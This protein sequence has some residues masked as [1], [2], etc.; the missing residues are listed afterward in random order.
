MI[1]QEVDVKG[2]KYEDRINFAD[3]SRL[4]YKAVL[5]CIFVVFLGDIIYYVTSPT[6]GDFLSW[7][8]KLARAVVVPT[9]IQLIILLVAIRVTNHYIR[10]DNPIMQ[11][12]TTCTLASLLCFSM[13]VFFYEINV[14]Y[15][16][17]A[18]PMFAALLYIDRKPL[19]YVFVLD[20]LLYGLF[21]AL[22][23]P[24][25]PDAVSARHG[26]YE[27]MAII[28]FMVCV[29]IIANGLLAAL[30]KLVNNIIA[31]DEQLK[32]DSF[33]MLFNHTAF[34]ERL[35]VMINENMTNGTPFTLVIWDID[36]FKKVNDTYGHE[37]GDKV[38]LIFA[39]TLH[40]MVG[41]A[42]YAFRYG[43]DEFTMLVRM[44]ARSASRL[45]LSIR[46]TFTRMTR[47]LK[48]NA[49][50]T[51]SAGL[52]EYNHK[53]FYGS[54]DFF[55]AC[56]DALYAAKADRNTIKIWQKNPEE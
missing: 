45:A 30:S 37:L 40:N 46:D 47:D 23:L 7:F 54:N 49:K 4:L 3:W 14:V 17:M 1:W 56:D 31:K 22:I 43:G 15:V 29:F 12:L 8:A 20:L 6:D 32:R 19:I 11:A 42:N 24:S 5:L 2:L 13:I 35:E 28:E 25:L 9:A 53:H 50:F 10:L 52:C 21:L 44:D 18:V 48:R 41:D 55:K 27:R 26:P 16:V 39:E 38:I 36:N 33:T 51:L 34:Y